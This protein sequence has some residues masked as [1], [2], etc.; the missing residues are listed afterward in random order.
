MNS[1][2]K[3][4][5]GSIKVTDLVFADDVLSVELLEVLVTG[6]EVLHEEAKPLVRNA[7]S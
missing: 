6:L 5:V 4:P 2:W 1:H 3:A 7:E